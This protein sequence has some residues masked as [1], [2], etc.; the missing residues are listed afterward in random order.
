MSDF[1]ASMPDVGRFA[2][3]AVFALLIAW[4]LFVPS[5]RL[6]DQEAD[7]P[8]AWWRDSRR[9]AIAIASVQVAIYLFWPD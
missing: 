7:R 1:L 2:F 6:A 3:A 5:T 4:L 8:T 9:W